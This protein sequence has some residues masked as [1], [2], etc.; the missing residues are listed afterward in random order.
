[1]TMWR[2]TV[3][4]LVLCLI[5]LPAAWAEQAVRDGNF[6]VHY[7]A[8]PTLDLEPDVAARFG[9]KRSRVR[10]LLVLSPQVI[11]DEGRTRSIPASGTG[12]VR[13]LLGQRE[14]LALRSAREGDVYYLIAEF[15]PLD[16]Q[17]I[18]INAEVLPS[19][20]TRPLVIDFTQK[21]FH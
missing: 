11:D 8:T 4:A 10:V 19:G 6:V 12:T 15:E 5:A 7:A 1:M 18:V 17:P 3:F 13:N 20:A 2:S 9:V 21:F 14:S 16:Q